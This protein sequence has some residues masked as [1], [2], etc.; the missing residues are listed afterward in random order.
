MNEAMTRQLSL[1]RS[2]GLKVLCLQTAG[3]ITGI[4]LMYLFARYSSA[5]SLA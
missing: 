5:I 1:S 2:R 3:L 4:A